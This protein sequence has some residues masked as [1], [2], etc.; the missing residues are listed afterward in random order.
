M[1]TRSG[2]VSQSLPDV[3][4][5]EAPIIA[6]DLPEVAEW[7]TD[8]GVSSIPLTEVM[9]IT[10]GAVLAVNATPETI[11]FAQKSQPGVRK[12]HLVQSV[13]GDDNHTVRYTITQ[14]LAADP[15]ACAQRL[16]DIATVIKSSSGRF[17]LTGLGTDLTVRPRGQVGLIYLDD[18]LIKPGE[19]VSGAAFFEIGLANLKI[20]PGSVFLV[21][22]HCRARGM[23]AARDSVL[24][25]AP[26]P[27]EWVEYRRC[28][29]EAGV[30][31]HICDNQ[32]VACL[33]DGRDIK[34][35]IAKWTGGYGLRITEC[36]IGTNR[37]V[38]TGIDWSLN[39][40]MNEG[41]QGIHLAVGLPDDGMH[42]DF[43]CPEV[44][45]VAG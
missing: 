6:T 32:L 30:D 1:S 4:G 31:L 2:G 42:F 35:E 44:A 7:L 16:A 17:S 21:S 14:W 29:A 18:P 33:L 9:S 27:A 40:L 43:I 37:Q 5:G 10:E 26:E 3:F 38:L 34:D 13:H 11:W 36:S 8:S 23:I 28:I 41:A 19:C 39:S 22:G 15:W 45:L 20:G 25:A 12:I 24:S